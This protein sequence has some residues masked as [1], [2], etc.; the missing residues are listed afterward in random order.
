VCFRRGNLG[1]TC[2]GALQ[3]KPKSHRDGPGVMLMGREEASYIATLCLGGMG[4][5]TAAVY[6]IRA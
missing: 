5:A 6:G 4:A 1:V 2:T 3:N